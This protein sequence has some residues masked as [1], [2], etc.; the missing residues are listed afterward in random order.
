MLSALLRSG[1]VKNYTALGQDGT[2]VY[3]VAS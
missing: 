1:D 3:A 2:S